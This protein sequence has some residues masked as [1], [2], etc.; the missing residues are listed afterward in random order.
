MI[1]MMQK[2][3]MTSMIIFVYRG[4]AIQVAVAFF[5]TFGF[6]IAVMWYQPLVNKRL[7]KLQ[8]FSLIITC[9][10]LFLGLMKMSPKA[11]ST[12]G[13]EG[14]QDSFA[15]FFVFGMNILVIV[16]PFMQIIWDME[17]IWLRLKGL[18]A[19]TARMDKQNAKLAS[20]RSIAKTVRSEESTNPGAPIQMTERA[21]ENCDNMRPGRSMADESDGDELAGVRAS[22]PTDYVRR[23]LPNLFLLTFMHMTREE[24]SR[25]RITNLR[26]LICVLSG[27]SNPRPLFQDSSR[28]QSP[29]DL[30]LI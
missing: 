29:P 5:L 7:A 13:S 23:H 11:F 14:G 17:A 21:G 18:L 20:T 1:V 25:Y 30:W 9:L 8:V 26:L 10:T 4:T 16:L 28:L 2:L 6:L 12:G 22:A 3:M 24:A 19:R 27:R 15:D